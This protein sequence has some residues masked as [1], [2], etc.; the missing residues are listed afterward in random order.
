M[1]IDVLEHT[2]VQ[3]GEHVEQH[4]ERNKMNV[5]LPQGFLDQ[6]IIQLVMRG[7]ITAF[8]P[9]PDGFLI[10]PQTHD[11]VFLLRLRHEG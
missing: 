8:R 11:G 3:E 5:N 10:L 4:Q 1:S 2:S 7:S 9:T 6:T